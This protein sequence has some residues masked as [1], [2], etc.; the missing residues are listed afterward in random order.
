MKT[1]RI[2][3]FFIVSLFL[4]LFFF[5]SQKQALAQNYNYQ[6]SSS[7]ANP[8]T[9]P[10]VPKNLHTYSQSVIIELMSSASCLVI[11]VDPISVNRKCLGI[12][13]N[14]G[15]IGYVEK[16]NGLIGISANLIAMTYIPPINTSDYVSYVANSF[17]ITKNT[18]AQGAGVGFDGI[19]PLLNLWIVFRDIVYLLFVIV[20]VFIGIAIMLR[21][22]ID[23]RT[24]MSIQNQIPKIIVA[25]ILVTF[26]FAI[27][28]FLIDLMWIV[29][30]LIINLFADANITPKLNA[31]QT[32]G[33]I[34]SN[35]FTFI[36]N[37]LSLGG[38]GL[39][40]IPV[41]IGKTVF[42]I[43][44]NLFKLDFDTGGW[45][46]GFINSVTSPIRATFGVLGGMAAFL[47]ITI[48]LAIALFRLW[49]SLIQAYVM[50]ILDIIIA[51]FWIMS[52]V[53]PGRSSGFGAWFRDILANL[54]AFPA[55]IFIFVLTERLMNSY[56]TYSSSTVFIPPLLGG[57]IAQDSVKGII[58]FGM[59]MATPKIVNM[60]KTMLKAP[61]YD[62]SSVI[63]GTTAA[64]GVVGQ[65][66]KIG[67]N[68]LTRRR[69]PWG[70]YSE[71]KLRQLAFGKPFNT[72][73]SLRAKA[74]RK[75]REWV[76]GGY[77]AQGE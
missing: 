21:V 62:T 27:A 9:N 36:D 77:K 10:N 67:W 17:G 25:L 45:V 66:S 34:M 75:V 1:A 14:T 58:A 61:K 3:K 59:I 13:T 50:I 65:P 6:P 44:E 30:F 2:V 42:G 51:P 12:D 69:D 68:R 46:S 76:E 54:S 19:K 72:N 5:S 55:V 16:N 71:G 23:P 38:Y 37:S 41:S 22:K 70:H 28:G 7:Y 31:A 52:G 43:V 26:S 33:Y 18:Y 60:T 56:A 63:S 73:T 64:A 15:K 20:F 11:G 53:I 29:C 40:Q 8:E 35:P 32:A 48:A 49:F 24:V 47:V 57:T 4:V 74:Q 39:F